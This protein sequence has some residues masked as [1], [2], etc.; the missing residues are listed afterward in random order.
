MFRDDH[1][2]L[3]S[4]IIS[5]ISQLERQGTHPAL[6]LVTVR[7]LLATWTAHDMAH[8]T[9]VGRTLA[10]R[11]KQEVGPWAQFLPVMK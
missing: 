10:K 5:V 2:P 4:N 9:Q 8:V 1:E 6:G 3:L 11:F 7:Q